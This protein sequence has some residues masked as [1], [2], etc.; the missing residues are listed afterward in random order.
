MDLMP[1]LP[2]RF[3]VGVLALKNNVALIRPLF[4]SSKKPPFEQC[5]TP[6]ELK[7]IQAN[8]LR[9][10]E[11]RQT[12]PPSWAASNT[13]QIP[14]L[15]ELAYSQPSVQLAETTYSV[16]LE[17][18]GQSFQFSRE[19]TLLESGLDAGLDM[20]FSCTMGGCAACKVTVLKGEVEM[21]EPHCLTEEEQETG[22][23]LACIARPRGPLILD[24]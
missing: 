16:R 21:E 23:V 7:A 1:L 11:E 2:A 15:A 8:A 19:K 17:K 20:D 4:I 9:R 12:L 5:H 14:D 10:K 6:E 3:R 24:I 18:S 13:A 22:A